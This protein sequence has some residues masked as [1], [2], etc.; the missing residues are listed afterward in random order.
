MAGNDARQDGRDPHAPAPASVP[1][2]RGRGR[3]R[4]HV[5]VF[6]RLPVAGEVKT[7]LM[8]GL[9]AD[10]GSKAARFYG[11][12][13]GH[14]V[15]EAL[16]CTGVARVW[17]F[18]SRAGDGDAVEAFVRECVGEVPWRQGGVRLR[19]RAQRGDTGDLGAKMWGAFQDV[20]RSVLEE[21]SEAEAEAEAESGVGCE[22]VVLMGT[23]VPGVT[24]RDVERA[25]EGLEGET[26]AEVVVCPSEDG[27]YWAIGMRDDAGRRSGVKG[28]LV[29]E[30][31]PTW[32]TPGV[33]ASTRAAAEEEH[34]RLGVEGM[35]VL[36]DIDTRE[37]L[38]E[39]VRR[40]EADKGAGVDATLLGI[41]RDILT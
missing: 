40:A 35:R 19:F 8:A 36:S 18:Y 28:L 39:W 1:A 5:V 30:R 6:L 9:G 4:R 33:L 3:A 37:D 16:G 14:V 32:S 2:Q 20:F 17:V 29:G 22:H 15:R 11:A 34:V 23:D 13:A 25:F 41:A 12:C 24:S 38:E 7:R 10:G 26:G 27:G 21:G 31:A